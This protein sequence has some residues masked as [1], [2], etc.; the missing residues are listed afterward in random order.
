VQTLTTELVT[1]EIAF[2]EGPRWHDGRLWVADGVADQIKAVDERGGV[3]VVL[4]TH[5][6]SGLGWLPDGTLVFAA[7]LTPRV[8]GWDGHDVHVVHDFGAAA[9]ST[10][11]L[12]AGPDGRIYV[13]LYQR[14]GDQIT[15]EIGLVVPSGGGRV[16]AGDMWRP[17]GMAIT[18]DGTTLVVSDT[19]GSAILAF[20]IDAEGNLADRRT[21]AAMGD[22][23]PDGLCLDAEGAVWVGCFDDGEFLRVLE[24]GEITHRVECPGVWA[25]AP[26]LGGEDRRTLFLVVNDT[27]DERLRRRE[28]RGR[29][30]RVR[31]EVPGV[32]WP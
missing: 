30:E 14:D 23:H 25:A 24:G 11:D 21:F 26:A 7:V 18:P 31:V 10:N 5:H 19:Y 3:E 17:N 1:D 29:I 32:G 16:V 22:R 8:M 15:G 20:T 13:D 28:S 27:D 9:W 12:V 4:E 6:P 2:G